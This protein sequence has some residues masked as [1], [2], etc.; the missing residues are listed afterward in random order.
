MSLVLAATLGLFGSPLELEWDAPDTCPTAA[1]IEARVREAVGE[2]QGPP[3]RASARITSATQGSFTVDLTLAQDD[4]PPARRSVSGATCAEVSDAAVLILVIAIDPDAAAALPP[5]GS[6]P[7][8]EPAAEPDPPPPDDGRDTMGV[9]EPERTIPDPAPTDTQDPGSVPAPEP[10]TVTPPS[11]PRSDPGSEPPSNGEPED[12]ST[13]AP[14][15]RLGLDILAGGGLALGVLPTATGFVGLHAALV[16]KRWRAE[17]GG[18]YEAPVDATAPGRSELGARAQ[19]WS[20]DARGCATLGRARLSV[21]LCGGIRVGLLHAEGTGA[22]QT[23]DRA[24]SPWV[25]VSAAPTLLWRPT[26]ARERL[27]LGARAEAS[28]SL[29]RPGFATAQGSSVLEGGPIGGQFSALIGY[30]LRRR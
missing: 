27:V 6:D 19:L 13:R 22:L 30:A 7:G 25:A 29:T 11:A 3:L 20:V 23:S 28:V 12:A 18:A 1:A 24:A 17:L 10:A 2:T 5:P 8:S 4:G 21:P 26:F 14:P 9:P 15:A 16:G